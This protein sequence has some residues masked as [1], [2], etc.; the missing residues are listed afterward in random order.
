MDSAKSESNTEEQE[1]VQKAKIHLERDEHEKAVPYLEK[2]VKFR[3]EDP[4]LWNNLGVAY[5]NAGMEDKG[6]EAFD[7]SEALQKK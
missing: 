5:V 6:K 1:I 3:P 2:A 7:K 4:V